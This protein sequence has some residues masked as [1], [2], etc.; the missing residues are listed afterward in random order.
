MDDDWHRIGA[1]ELLHVAAREPSVVEVW[2]LEE[3]DGNRTP[4]TRTVRV[5]GT[6]QPISE[7]DVEFLGT[8]LVPGVRLVWHLFGGAA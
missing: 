6:G 5:Y 2:T 7:A 4:A 8:A 1:G 3:P